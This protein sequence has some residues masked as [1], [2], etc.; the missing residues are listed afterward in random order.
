MLVLRRTTGESI[1]IRTPGGDLVRVVICDV[2]GSQVRVG[3][4]A[5]LTYRIG[6]SEENPFGDAR[7]SSSDDP[8]R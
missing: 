1:L 6:R 2:R 3:I 7:A 4:D 5:P 8:A